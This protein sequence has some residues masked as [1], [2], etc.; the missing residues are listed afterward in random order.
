VRVLQLCCHLSSSL[1]S[2]LGFKLA[3]K[4]SK[5]IL[6]VTSLG[7]I[8]KT[9]TFR[10]LSFR[11]VLPNS[12]KRHISHLIVEINIIRILFL[13]LVLQQWAYSLQQIHSCR[14]AIKAIKVLHSL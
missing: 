7:F 4:A 5:S 12:R 9:Q 13:Q 6:K 2:K 11:P 8:V 10:K 1:L 14:L 3:Q